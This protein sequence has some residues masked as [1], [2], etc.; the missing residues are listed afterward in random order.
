MLPKDSSP[1]SSAFSFLLNL[2]GSASLHLIYQS[3]FDLL[4]PLQC[5]LLAYFLHFY[6][7]SSPLLT[8]IQ[9]DYINDIA[10]CL[11]EQASN[12]GSSCFFYAAAY[13]EGN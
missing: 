1:T 11:L 4:P 13:L 9:E 6:H 5:H 2:M 3:S 10:R 8:L 12:S 7:E